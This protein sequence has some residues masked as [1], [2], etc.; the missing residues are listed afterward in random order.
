MESAI[1]CWEREVPDGKEIEVLK[2][3]RQIGEAM[4]RC[5]RSWEYLA[6]LLAMGG[7]AVVRYSRSRQSL[8][9]V[10]AAMVNAL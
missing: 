8:P 2:A 7:R 5:A 4:G 3:R 10:E 6:P 1:F 9:R